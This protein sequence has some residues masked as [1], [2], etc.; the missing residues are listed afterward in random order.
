MTS[1]DNEKITKIERKIDVVGQSH[2][3][4]SDSM[5]VIKELTESRKF[6]MKRVDFLIG[7]L[8]VYTVILISIF[9]LLAYFVPPLCQITQGGYTVSVP[10]Q[11]RK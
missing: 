8:C 10:I 5:K 2:V 4:L 6:I 9:V 11:T 7:I 3:I 1:Y